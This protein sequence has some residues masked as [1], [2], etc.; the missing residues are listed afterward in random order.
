[1]IVK[2]QTSLASSGGKRTVLVYNQDRSVMFE[3]DDK[4]Q[5]DVLTQKLRG[6]PKGYFKT[7][8]LDG[9]LFVTERTS[10]RDW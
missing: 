5:V 9:K 4:A 3:T 10:D 7:M 2:V 8:T 6:A 1:M